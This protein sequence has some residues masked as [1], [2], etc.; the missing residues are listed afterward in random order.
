MDHQ[1]RYALD[2]LLKNP[3]SSVKTDFFAVRERPAVSTDALNELSTEG[4]VTGHGWACS[5][6]EI[7]EAGRQ[8]LIDYDN[9]SWPWVEWWRKLR[10]KEK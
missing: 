9:Q 6:W 4:L 10:Q 7:T 3:H 2:W 5:P 8:A 1:K